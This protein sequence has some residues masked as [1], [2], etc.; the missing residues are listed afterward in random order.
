MRRERAVGVRWWV[1]DAS[2][3]PHTYPGGVE[4]HLSIL[5]VWPVTSSSGDQSL[6]P[7]RRAGVNSTVSC[8]RESG[9]TSS[10]PGWNPLP[11]SPWHS[12]LPPGLISHQTLNPTDLRG[13]GFPLLEEYTEHLLWVLEQPEDYGF[14][15]SSDE[16]GRENIRFSWSSCSLALD[17]VENFLPLDE[18]RPYV[19]LAVRYPTVISKSS[20]VLVRKAVTS[21]RWLLAIWDAAKETSVVHVNCI[22]GFEN[23]T[24]NDV[25][26]FHFLY[27]VY[28]ILSW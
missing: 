21:Y 7:G 9:V 18:T 25:K 20:F 26:Y 2:A 6:G 23:N 12:V 17:L 11:G 8:Y 22:P 14:C 10:T 24:R 27:K 5:S 3:C 13:P 15:I 19:I 16:E 1:D 28:I 4:L